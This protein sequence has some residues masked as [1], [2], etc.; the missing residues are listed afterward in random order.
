MSTTGPTQAVPA[1]EPAPL[2]LR[3]CCRLP[4]ERTPVWLMRQAG[5]YMPEYRALRSKH[6]ILDI[7]RTPDLAAEVT[8][9]PIRAF[10]FDAAIIFADILPPLVGMGLEL[11]FNEGEGPRIGNRITSSRDVDRLGTPPAEETM[12]HTLEAIRIVA[13]ELEASG[14]PVIGFA[15]APFTLACYAIEGG[16]SKSFTKAKALMFGEPAAWKRLMTKLVTVQA[17][18]L[19]AQARAGAR[20]LQVFDSWAGIA[21]GLTDYRRFALPYN[22]MLFERLKDVGVPVI[23]FGMGT[24]WYIEEVVRAGGDV[25]SVDWRRPLDEAWQAIGYERAIQGN[26]DP[27]ALHAPWR[28]LRFQIDE[29]LA[30]AGGRPGHIF[31]LGHGVLPDTPVDTVRRL[32]DYVRE[33]T[34][35][36]R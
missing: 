22:A 34:A 10:G 26:L 16:T 33:R 8:L 7:I 32:V 30:R 2:F 15:G 14:T 12:P 19:A 6:G 24:S 11:A 9:Q 1:L 27:A 3:A 31:N 23:N 18:Y 35:A 36:A 28:E 5:R 29:I 20:A 13:R 17:D 25:I 4:V 21:L